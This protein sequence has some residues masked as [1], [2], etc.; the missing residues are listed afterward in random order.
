MNI[1]Y[2]YLDKLPL[3]GY[4]HIAT[5][6]LQWEILERSTE[7]ND[8]VQ[9]TRPAHSLNGNYQMWDDKKHVSVSDI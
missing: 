4:V 3:L 9:T 2:T 6:S 8:C 5:L 7:D 1:N